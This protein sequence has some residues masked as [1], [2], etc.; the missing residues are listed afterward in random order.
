[1]K[2]SIH[3]VLVREYT[4]TDYDTIL[5]LPIKQKDA[6]ELLN[7]TNML[8][9]EYMGWH[10]ENF[11]NKT[12]VIEYADEIVGIIGIDT[13]E[14]ILWFTTKKLSRQAEFS[15]VRSF[16]KILNELLKS[17]NTKSII[18]YVDSTYTETLKWIELGGFKRG[19]E[20]IINDNKFFIMK[21][22]I[23]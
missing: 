23:K 3:K 18:V 17:E 11:S 19:K 22:T 15:L 21:Y 9:I 6:I 5:N 1:M 16:N 14:N 4:D 13:T 10:L 8:P 12:K 20:V 2:Y 7:M